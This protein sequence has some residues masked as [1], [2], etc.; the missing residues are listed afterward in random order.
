VTLRTHRGLAVFLA[1][2]VLAPLGLACSL[3]DVVT[4]LADQLARLDCRTDAA[5]RV[6]T[7]RTALLFAHDHVYKKPGEPDRDWYDTF[8][9]EA[10]PRTYDDAN[11]YLEEHAVGILFG[12]LNRDL[13]ENAAMAPV[14]VT[15]GGFP[16]DPSLPVVTAVSKGAPQYVHVHWSPSTTTPGVGGYGGGILPD[17][18]WLGVI[19]GPSTRQRTAVERRRTFVHEFGHVLELEHSD[20]A[21]NFMNESTT[22]DTITTQQRADMWDTLNSRRPLWLVLSCRRDAALRQIVRDNSGGEIVTAVCKRSATS[23]PRT[24]PSIPGP[25]GTRPPC[26]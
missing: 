21:G 15:A 6:G 18:F 14:A 10:V 4:S 16:Q 20:V 11:A 17:A 9:N 19:E 23:P 22:G 2:A 5:V 12:L 8:V 24:R 1:G 13:T 7:D 25:A 3:G 26:P